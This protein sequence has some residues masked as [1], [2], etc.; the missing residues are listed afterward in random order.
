MQKGN[1]HRSK[2]GEGDRK[3]QKSKARTKEGALES[4]RY[5]INYL[6]FKLFKIRSK[7]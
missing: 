5:S 4:D 3:M 6:I 7:S 2:K 1:M